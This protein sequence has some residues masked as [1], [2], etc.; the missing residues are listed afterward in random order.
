VQRARAIQPWA[1]SAPAFGW[2]VPK[3]RDVAG[4]VADL[5][6]AL[7]RPEVGSRAAASR[8]AVE[9]VEAVELKPP[10]RVSEGLERR[11]RRSLAVSR[12]SG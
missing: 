3:L 5:R 9:A 11:R 12:V 8:Q 4:R 1:G 7:R 6:V 10:A 2:A